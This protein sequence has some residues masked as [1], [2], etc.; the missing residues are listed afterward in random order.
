MRR[1]PSASGA[2]RSAAGRL[3]S[4]ARGSATEPR[5]VRAGVEAVGR[6]PWLRWA[7]R[8]C[9]TPGINEPLIC[10]ESFATEACIGACSAC[11]SAAFW[12]IA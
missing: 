6:G 3:A 1:R 4:L 11:W 5:Q 12:L 8:G 7:V 10:H 9:G 2:A